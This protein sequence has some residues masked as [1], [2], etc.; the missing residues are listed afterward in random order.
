MT[1][2]L[3]QYALVLWAII[4]RPWTLL[5]LGLGVLYVGPFLGAWLGGRAVPDNDRL[6]IHNATCPKT[7]LIGALACC[8]YGQTVCSCSAH[9]CLR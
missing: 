7:C 1:P 8:G 4:S 9:N 5:K 3:R 6:S 2:I